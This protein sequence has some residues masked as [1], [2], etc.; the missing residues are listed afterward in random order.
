MVNQ[1]LEHGFSIIEDFQ[2][3]FYFFMFYSKWILKQ[4]TVSKIKNINAIYN[5]AI[6]ISEID[7]TALNIFSEYLRN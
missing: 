2:R 5:H 3:K 1:Q 6:V 7:V 4:I